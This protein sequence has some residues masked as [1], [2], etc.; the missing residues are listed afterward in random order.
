MKIA[1]LQIKNSTQGFTLSEL[2]VTVAI[3]TIMISITLGSRN[4]YT[5]RLVLKTEMYNATLTLRKA[6]VYSLGVKGSVAGS[7]PT[8]FDTSYGVSFNALANDTFSLFVDENIDRDMDPLEYRDVFVIG[9][10]VTV[11][12]ICALLGGV[13]T[14][15]PDGSIARIDVTFNRPKPNARVKV[16]TSSGTEISNTSTP[17]KIYFVNSSGASSFIQIDYTGSVSAPI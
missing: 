15:S 7:N 9:N 12:K 11:Q 16:M 4:T 1:K 5:E 8:T 2:I 3:I 13:E 6:Q 10:K 14:C 17:V